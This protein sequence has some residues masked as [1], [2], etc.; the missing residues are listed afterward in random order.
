MTAR[1]K[2]FLAAGAGQKK[3]KLDRIG[4]LFPPPETVDIFVGKEKPGSITQEKSPSKKKK[5]GGN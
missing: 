3:Q 1:K 4:K 5:G 2:R